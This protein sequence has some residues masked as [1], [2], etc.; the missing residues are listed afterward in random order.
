MWCS[1]KWR[2]HFHLSEKEGVCKTYR[3][4]SEN[5]NLINSIRI[6]R[7]TPGQSNHP[8]LKGHTPLRIYDGNLERWYLLDNDVGILTSFRLTL[9][10]FLLLIVC[11]SLN[12]LFSNLALMTFFS[13]SVLIKSH[14]LVKNTTLSGLKHG[15]SG[16]LSAIFL[17]RPRNCKSIKASHTVQIELNLILIIIQ[18]IIVISKK[19]CPIFQICKYSN[20]VQI[21]KINGTIR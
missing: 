3:S 14:L 9:K 19:F 15:I 6:P 11:H 5:V 8:P 17:M 18:I 10:R 2:Y 16:L 12:S 20:Y 13:L 1:I 7:R 21:M 4:A